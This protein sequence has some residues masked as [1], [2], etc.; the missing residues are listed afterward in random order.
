MGEFVTGSL[1]A[2]IALPLNNILMLS[3]GSGEYL[4]TTHTQL[5]MDVTMNTLPLRLER[6]EEL[7]FV[8]LSVSVV[9]STQ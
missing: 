6:R 4:T 8:R 9:T 2:Q 5:V 1:S 7:V 3:D